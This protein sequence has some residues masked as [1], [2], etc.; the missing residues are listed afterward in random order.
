MDQPS[1][2]WRAAVRQTLEVL[3]QQGLHVVGITSATPDAGVTRLAHALALASS[4]AGQRTLLLTFNGSEPEDAA[5]AGAAAY[6]VLGPSGRDDITFPLNNAQAL[7][8]TLAS[9][10]EYEAVIANLP[11]VLGSGGAVNAITVARACDGVV[12]VCLAGQVT[13]QQVAQAS[14]M[15]TLAHVNIAGT[16]LNEEISPP[17]SEQ[18]AR[19]V[20][21]LTGFAPSLSRR[22]YEKLATAQS[23]QGS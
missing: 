18:L 12:F 1:P 4:E 19:A 10:G 5:Q 17:F 6:D 9:F 23:L 20:F 16:V 22:L 7:K 11:P 3:N 14:E 2:E 15:M 21:R 13:S 8:A